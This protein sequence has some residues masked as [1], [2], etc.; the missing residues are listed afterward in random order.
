MCLMCFFVA[1]IKL[2]AAD[3][4]ARIKEEVKAEIAGGVRAS[5]AAV[6]VGEDP[7]AV[8]TPDRCHLSLDFRRVVADEARVRKT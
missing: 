1:M 4:A 8:E 5:L 6:R 7:A 2:E 3:L